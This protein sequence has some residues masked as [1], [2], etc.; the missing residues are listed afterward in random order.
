MLSLLL[1]KEIGVMVWIGFFWLK[2]CSTVINVTSGLRKARGFVEL[3]LGVSVSF[4]REL[5]KCLAL[6]VLTV[7]CSA[8]QKLCRLPVTTDGLSVPVM[9]VSFTSGS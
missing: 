2:V 7:W 5:W 9:C 8:W 3:F 1:V 6:V 4:R